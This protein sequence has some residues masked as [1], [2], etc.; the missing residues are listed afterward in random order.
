[1]A[2]TSWKSSG[3]LNFAFFGDADDSLSD[4]LQND[5]PAAIVTFFGNVVGDAT[6]WK[7]SGNAV[8]STGDALP[9]DFSKSSFPLVTIRT[10]H[11]GFTVD[12]VETGSSTVVRPRTEIRIY[13]ETAEVDIGLQKVV[14]IG[15][16]IASAIQQTRNG[17]AAGEWATFY[18]NWEDPRVS[19]EPA[20]YI[21]NGAGS[22]LHRMR[23]F[24]EWA[25]HD[26]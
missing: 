15:G 17:T 4:W 7:T 14:E 19:A 16:A 13:H 21:D 2:T 8:I 11:V 3:A 23:L 25:H 10:G 20:E 18:C 6:H 9:Y 12:Y 22:P 26:D 1:V 24:V 5:A